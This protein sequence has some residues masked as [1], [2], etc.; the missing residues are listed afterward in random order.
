MAVRFPN[1]LVFLFALQVLLTF[2]VTDLSAN[3]AWLHLA[4]LASTV[5]YFA[6]MVFAV[7]RLA[8]YTSVRFD[9]LFGHSILPFL[10]VTAADM[11]LV[12]KAVHAWNPAA[13]VALLIVLAC[14]T[15]L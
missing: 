11:W 8:K 2:R 14:L 6:L 10:Q 7:P 3:L 15:L 4:I 12:A 1:F 9:S 5:A 13:L